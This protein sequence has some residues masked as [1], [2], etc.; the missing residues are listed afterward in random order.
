L[1]IK[2]KKDFKEVKSKI[3]IKFKMKM[4]MKM[5]M[6]ILEKMI[7][8]ISLKLEMMNRENKIN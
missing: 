2:S 1:K 3:K 8:K 5:K 7:K 4:K 6:I